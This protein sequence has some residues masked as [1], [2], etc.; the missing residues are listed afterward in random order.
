MMRFAEKPASTILSQD[1]AEVQIIPE[2]M[3]D[4]ETYTI[5]HK[6]TKLTDILLKMAQHWI[7]TSF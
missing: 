5:H 1:P 6:Y 3:P 4:S 7:L 2:D